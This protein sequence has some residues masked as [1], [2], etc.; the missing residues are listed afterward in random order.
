MVRQLFT[1]W[2]AMARACGPVTVYA[3]KT[4]IVFQSDVRFAGA[5]T[6]P[7]WLEATIW[8]TRRASHRCL[9]RVESFGALGYGLHFRL[10][11]DADL[12]S[13]LETLLRES[14][15]EHGRPAK[16]PRGTAAQEKA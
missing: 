14:Y 6:H 11:E 8:L 9:Y 13:E 7:D 5:V 2:R 10:G 3:Q 4:R 1:R 12:D 16:R 15:T